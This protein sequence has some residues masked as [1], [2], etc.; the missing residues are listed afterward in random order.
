MCLG[1]L[2]EVSERQL[3]AKVVKYGLRERT[4]VKI[5]GSQTGTNCS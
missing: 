4:G 2:V 1:V 5:G 3:N